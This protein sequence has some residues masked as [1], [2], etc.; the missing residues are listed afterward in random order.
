MQHCVIFRSLAEIPEA[1]W[2]AFLPA[3]RRLVQSLYTP[4][5]SEGVEPSIKSKKCK[6]SKKESEAEE[7]QKNGHIEIP[8]NIYE[9]VLCCALA[10]MAGKLKAIESRSALT[11]HPGM[12]AYR[13]DIPEHMTAHKKGL[14]YSLLSNQLDPETTESIRNLSF[15]KGRKVS[16]A[17]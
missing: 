10:K 1:T 11:A 12:T 4:T 9:K 14:C 16:L 15:I 6:K 8:S 5:N 13:L 2:S 17:Y 7:E 3:A